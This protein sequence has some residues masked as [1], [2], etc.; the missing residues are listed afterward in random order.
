[1]SDP[2]AQPVDV[3]QAIPAGQI[4]YGM[5]LPIQS[6]STLYV[7]DW[8]KAARVDDL[9]HIAQVADDAGFFYIGVCDHTAIPERLAD[10]M[11]TTWY[12][13]VATL[14]WLAALTKRTHRRIRIADR[15]L[16]CPGPTHRRSRFGVGAG[17]YVR[18][19]RATRSSFSRLRAWH[20][21]SPGAPAPTSYL[22]RRF[23]TGSHPP[24]GR[25]R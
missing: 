15:G 8:E 22:D 10:A 13:T 18:I 5:Q 7:A 19:S 9:G 12:D 21:P 4:V 6:Q 1:M 23:V 20:L 16:R 24:H 2:I 25:I 14:G 3:V 11:G 17:F